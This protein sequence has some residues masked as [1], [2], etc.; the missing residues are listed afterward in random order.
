MDFARRRQ[1]QPALGSIN[2]GFIAAII[3]LRIFEG[4]QEERERRGSSLG[5]RGNR[6]PTGGGRKKKKEIKEKNRQKGESNRQQ[7]IYRALNY[8][9]STVQPFDLASARMYRVLLDTKYLE[10]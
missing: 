4:C 3:C 1:R 6:E 9:I 5:R 8:F 10:N 2:L 7:T